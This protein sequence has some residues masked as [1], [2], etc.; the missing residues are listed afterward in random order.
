MAPGTASPRASQVQ[1]ASVGSLVVRAVVLGAGLGGIAVAARLARLR[2]DVTIVDTDDTLAWTE[3]PL[4]SPVRHGATARP[5]APPTILWLPAVFRDLFAST[6]RPLARELELA[7]VDPARRYVL[8]DGSVL[9][10]PTGNRGATL[11]AFGRAFG[12]PAATEWDAFITAARTRW[13]EVRPALTPAGPDEPPALRRRWHRARAGGTLRHASHHLVD[14]RNRLILAS[15]AY[16]AG[17]DPRRASAGLAVL[18]YLEHAFGAWQPVGGWPALH[19]AV[20]RR[21]RARG[22]DVAI[23]RMTALRTRSGGPAEIDLADGTTLEADVVIDARTEP[24]QARGGSSAG[25]AV[26]VL[27]ACHSVPDRLPAETIVLAPSA[28]ETVVVGRP[29]LVGRPELITVHA[30]SA[31]GL[32]TSVDG[33]A[34]GILARAS[35]IGVDL[36]GAVLAVTRAPAH[37]ARAGGRGTR[38]GTG[39]IDDPGRET[40]RMLRIGTPLG[41]SAAPPLLGLSAA[42]AAAM[43][44]PV[45]TA[46]S[47]RS[48]RPDAA[49]TL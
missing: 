27:V 40:D 44:E 20:L 2:H 7:A 1:S 8:P 21:A 6:G 41:G 14:P 26:T 22:A 29:D 16:A 23:A 32:T 31:A 12:A 15:Y 24:P 37:H 36:G 34:A 47:A 4:R 33:L 3:D 17:T 49:T 39:L 28:R 48:D 25:S 13:Q 42:L 35:R 30:R 46:P 45:A 19:G 5:G 11:D 38:S 43:V 10:L 9:D 18:P